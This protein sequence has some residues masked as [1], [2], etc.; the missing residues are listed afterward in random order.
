MSDENAVESTPHTLEHISPPWS[1]L[2]A[3]CKDCE[4]YSKSLLREL[5][6]QFKAHD[7]SPRGVRIVKTSCQKIC[8]KNGLT[9]S[10]LDGANSQTVVL[11]NAEDAA[12]CAEM[13]AH[14]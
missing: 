11:H 10:V 1:V 9:V 6:Q 14:R 3:A 5:K 4:A 8:P 13:I 2:V 12:C 7:L